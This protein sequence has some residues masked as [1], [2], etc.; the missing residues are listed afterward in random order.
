MEALGSR[1]EA[2]VEAIKNIRRNIQAMFVDVSWFVMVVV[3]FRF[4]YSEMA[5]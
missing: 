1:F 2:E 4:N 3:L 5:N